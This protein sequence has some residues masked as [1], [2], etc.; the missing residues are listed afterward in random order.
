MAGPDDLIVYWRPGCIYCDR[1]ERALR[2]LEETVI[3]VDVRKDSEA[4][5]FVASLRGGD[6]VVPTVVTRT[7]GMVAPEARA[8]RSRTRSSQPA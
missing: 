2:S 7:A 8:I 1:L 6:V 3:K 4:A 5:E